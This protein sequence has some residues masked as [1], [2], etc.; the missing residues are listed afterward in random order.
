MSQANVDVVRRIFD[1]W[2][3]PLRGIEIAAAALPRRK[4]RPDELQ[5]RRRQPHYS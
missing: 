3:R 4:R 1:V 5:V 2:M